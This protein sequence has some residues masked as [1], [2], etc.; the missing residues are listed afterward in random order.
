MSKKLDTFKQ[1]NKFSFTIEFQT[2][3]LRYLIQSKEAPLVLNKVKPGYFAL[4]EHA[5]ILEGI[6][7]FYKRY[8]KMSE[9]YFGYICGI[10]S[11][12]VISIIVS[13]VREMIR[14]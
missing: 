8:K 2:E 6:N 9:W 10:I 12:M 5:L 3:V 13:V 14:K 11:M 1:S 7:K 4:I